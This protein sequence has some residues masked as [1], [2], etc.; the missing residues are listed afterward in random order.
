ME[1]KRRLSCVFTVKNS[2]HPSFSAPLR[3]SNWCNVETIRTTAAATNSTLNVPKMKNK[4]Q[5]QER[6]M[7]SLQAK[8]QK[9]QIFKEKNNL[10][11]VFPPMWSHV[12]H[13]G[14]GGSHNN[15]NN[16]N[17]PSP[18]QQPQGPVVGRGEN[19][20]RWPLSSDTRPDDLAGGPFLYSFPSGP[21]RRSR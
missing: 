18:Q 17:P 19:R 1:M 12:L 11:L 4:P 6:K 3:G 9:R 20:L 21:L 7:L 8:H 5:N 15:N 14:I 13:L 16:N 10:L 2:P